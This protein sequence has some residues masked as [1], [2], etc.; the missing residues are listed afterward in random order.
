MIIVRLWGGLGNQLFQYATARALAE[1]HRCELKIDTS[2]LYENLDD[3]LTVKREFDLEVFKIKAPQASKK[4]IEFFNPPASNLSQKIKAKGLSLLY[5]KRVYSEKYFHF[6]PELSKQKPP[7]CIIGNWQSYKYFEKIEDKIRAELKFNKELEANSIEL[8]KEIKKSQS[9]C[10]NI[11]RGDYVD[12]PVYS[13][14]LGFRGLEYLLPAV[15][16]IKGLIDNPSFYIFSDDIQWCEEVLQPKIGGRIIDHSHKGWK[17]SN[18]LQLI[19]LCKHQIIP[20]STFGWWGAWL[21]QNPDKIVIAPRLWYQDE[22]YDT[23]DL[24]PD[25]WISL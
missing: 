9:V 14:T 20:N 2:L 5:P 24:C 3:P 15:E 21:N 17:F 13:K 25:E 23:K 19:S 4:E 11:R 12:H 6:D 10:I 7:L 22:K 1:Q 8:A 16:K 18:Y